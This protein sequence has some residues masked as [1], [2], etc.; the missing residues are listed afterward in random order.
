MGYLSRYPKIIKTMEKIIHFVGIDMSKKTFDC[1]V[2]INEQKDTSK[3]GQFNK[4][5]EGLHEFQAWLQRSGVMLNAQT[6]IC[7]EF[8][9]LYNRMLLAY[10]EKTNVVLWVERAV[11]IKRSLG[12]QRDKSDKLDAKR[13]AIFAWRNQDEM[14]PWSS[15]DQDVQKIKNLLAQRDRLVDTKTRLLVPLSEMEQEGLVAEAKELYK[16][17]KPVITQLDN[18]LINIE[19][20]IDK[21]ISNNKDLKTKSAIV[22][23]VKGVGNVICWYLIAST[24]GFK[25]LH[26]GK[27]LACYC[28]VVPFSS[29]SGTS[30]KGKPRVSHIAN[31]KLKTLMHMAAVCAIRHDKEIKIYY[32]RK[33]QEGK[34]KMSVLNAVRNKLILRIAA[35]LRDDRKYE[36][37]YVRKVA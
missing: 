12:L 36:D 27:S 11:H 9:G 34:H 37:N 2:I 13:I 1:N 30:I 14:K 5:T 8:T 32:D 3:H 16:L 33:I 28:G 10:L 7:M 26:S 22:K 18:S 29:T 15:L 21:I 19:K 6:L 20:T 31:K 4:T 24:K 17:Q 35:V 23:S 25:E